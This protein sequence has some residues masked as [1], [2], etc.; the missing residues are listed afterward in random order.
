MWFGRK[1]GEGVMIILQRNRENTTSKMIHDQ[2]RQSG[3]QNENN[4]SLFDTEICFAN[5]RN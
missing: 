5:N 3:G 2:V 1:G 4:E